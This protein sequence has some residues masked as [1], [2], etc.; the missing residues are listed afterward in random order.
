RRED[1][2]VTGGMRQLSDDLL[3]RTV[4]VV[5]R[6]VDEVAPGLG[7]GLDDPAALGLVGTPAP[8]GA[9]RHRAERQLRD[10]QPASA[11]QAVA[12]AVLL[13]SLSFESNRM[14]TTEFVHDATP[15]AQALRVEPRSGAA[16]EL[17]IGLSALTRPEDPRPLG[18]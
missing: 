11:D 10:P 15:A 9:E 2:A 13:H 4:G 8:V 12:H 16:F 5:A 6:R 18:A 1:P 14:S 7:V 17:L 3:A